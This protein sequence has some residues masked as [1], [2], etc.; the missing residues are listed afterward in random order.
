MSAA[1]R[2]AVGVLCNR[3]AFGVQCTREAVYL[4]NY[5]IRVK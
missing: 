5:E 1:S 4:R 2:E 3:K